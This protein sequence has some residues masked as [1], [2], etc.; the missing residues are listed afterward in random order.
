[1]CIFKTQK[2]YLRATFSPCT[3]QGIVTL[4]TL[5]STDTLRTI[6]L[7]IHASRTIFRASGTPGAIALQ[8]QHQYC[9]GK[10]S[11]NNQS[12]MEIQFH[13]AMNSN[14]SSSHSRRGELGL[15]K[16]WA[17]GIC[18][19]FVLPCWWNGGRVWRFLAMEIERHKKMGN[20]S[21]LYRTTKLPS[22]LCVSSITSR[23][24]MCGILPKY[25]WRWHTAMLQNFAKCRFSMPHVILLLPI[26]S[27]E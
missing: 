14:V 7:G 16:V 11:C 25:V 24:I 4:W 19:Y 9:V 5:P 20:N 13:R 23:I 8:S 18:A 2:V 22:M 27:F 10:T 3:M 17:W 26:L 12:E 21:F 6:E 1:M 15:A